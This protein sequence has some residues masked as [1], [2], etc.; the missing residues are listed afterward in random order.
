MASIDVQSMRILG[1]NRR[2]TGLAQRPGLG[3]RGSGEEPL[4]SS[5]EPSGSERYEAYTPSSES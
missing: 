1:G 4:N 2:R 3:A 5:P